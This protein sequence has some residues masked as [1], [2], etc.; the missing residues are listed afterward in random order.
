MSHESS[1]E[2]R[3]GL[4]MSVVGDRYVFLATGKETGGAMPGYF[5]IAIA[6]PGSPDWER[7][8]SLAPVLVIHRGPLPA[9]DLAPGVETI[10]MP[11][12]ISQLVGRLREWKRST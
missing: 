6:E 12:S 10:R 3:P 4:V 8:G 1:P 5:R 9:R 11:F 2:P 7:L